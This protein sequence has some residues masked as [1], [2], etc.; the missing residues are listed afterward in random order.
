MRLLLCKQK[1]SCRL[2]DGSPVTEF[3]TYFH[4]ITSMVLS[5]PCNAHCMQVPQWKSWKSLIMMLCGNAGSVAK[6][7][8]GSTFLWLS[9]LFTVSRTGC[10]DRVLP[11]SLFMTFNA[12][13]F[14]SQADQALYHR[15]IRVGSNCCNRGLCEIPSYGVWISIITYTCSS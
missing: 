14:P 9:L 8:I 10:F 6:K 15:A 3:C 7:G 12:F 5:M 4:S 11:T 13:P 1:G 2:G